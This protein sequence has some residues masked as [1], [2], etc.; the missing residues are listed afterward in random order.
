MPSIFGKNQCEFN[1]K[2]SVRFWD[3]DDYFK[4]IKVEIKNNIGEKPNLSACLV[5]FETKEKLKEFYEYYSS[6]ESNI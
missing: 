2:A 5:F 4:E 1:E 3:K 6:E